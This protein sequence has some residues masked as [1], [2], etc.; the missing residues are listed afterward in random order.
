MLGAVQSSKMIP[1]MTP[2]MTLQNG[3]LEVF[4]IGFGRFSD[5]F[6]RISKALEKNMLGVCE[7]SERSNVETEVSEATRNS[8]Q[9]NTLPVPYQDKF[10]L[11]CLWD[12]NELPGGS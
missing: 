8:Q 4:G 1:T 7:R 5:P 6:W 10:M 9:I 2:K 12:V 3:I 11:W